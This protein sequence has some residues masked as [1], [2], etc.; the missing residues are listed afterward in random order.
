MGKN[1]GRQMKI[2]IYKDGFNYYKAKTRNWMGF[3]VWKKRW[4]NILGENKVLEWK[5]KNILVV[6]YA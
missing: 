6:T 3:W 2:K 4:S 1:G 5:K